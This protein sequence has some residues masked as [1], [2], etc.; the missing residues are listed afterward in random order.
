MLCGQSCSLLRA[1]SS[2]NP[3]D[4]GLP[5]VKGLE[6]G[7]F[8]VSGEWLNQAFSALATCKQQLKECQE[9]EDEQ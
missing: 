8:E 1:N 6:N 5:L 4:V 3:S 9:K 7:D 2:P